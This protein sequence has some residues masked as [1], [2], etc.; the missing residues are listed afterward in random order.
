MKT[1]SLQDG[2]Q[3]MVGA[4]H[5]QM[6]LDYKMPQLRD[7]A[8]LTVCEIDGSV[9]AAAG[10]KLQAEAYLWI[11]QTL[12]PQ[13]KWDAIRLMQRE[14]TAQAVKIGISQ[15]VAYVPD[16]IKRF[17]KRMKMLR[18][19]RSRDGWTAWVYEVENASRAVPSERS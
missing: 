6:G 1:R 16:C 8:G 14:L 7:M 19:N 4:I 2:D 11:D 5:Q 18:W 10:L 17:A 15:V 3:E 13:Q 9:R 12:D